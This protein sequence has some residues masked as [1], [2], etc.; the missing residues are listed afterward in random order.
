MRWIPF[1]D[2]VHCLFLVQFACLCSLPAFF[3]QLKQTWL[4]FAAFTR[5]SYFMGERQGGRSFPKVTLTGNHRFQTISLA[6]LHDVGD[7]RN[8]TLQLLNSQKH[9]HHGNAKCF[10]TYDWNSK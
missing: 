3:R 7:M 10:S 4:A 9:S 8:S 2:F 6:F 5:S 1:S